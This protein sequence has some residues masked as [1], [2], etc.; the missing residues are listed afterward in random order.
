M[1]VGQRVGYQDALMTPAP[2]KRLVAFTGRLLLHKAID[3]NPMSNQNGADC[4]DTDCKFGFAPDLRLAISR[5]VE[6]CP[7]F[8]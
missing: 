6:N 2:M 7:L 1:A 3:L 8:R 5:M 4:K